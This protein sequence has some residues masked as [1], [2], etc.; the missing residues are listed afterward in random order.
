MKRPTNIKLSKEIKIQVQK[1]FELKVPELQKG[2]IALT[3]FH[4]KDKTSNSKIEIVYKRHS[5]IE[6]YFDDYTKRCFE[7]RTKCKIESVFEIELVKKMG[8]E[9]KSKSY[10][11]AVRSE[12]KRDSKTGKYD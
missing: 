8:F 1:K 9:H 4:Y 3:I 12:E 6:G 2:E 7:R 11:L 5:D 10:T